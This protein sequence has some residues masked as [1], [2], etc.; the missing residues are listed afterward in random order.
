MFELGLGIRSTWL[1]QHNV[2]Q[3]VC[4]YVSCSLYPHTVWCAP[5]LTH[6]STPNT[7]W[8]D[9]DHFEN[10]RDRYKTKLLY[11]YMCTIVLLY[12]NWLWQPPAPRSDMAL[13]RAIL[14]GFSVKKQDH[15]NNTEMIL[16]QNR[17]QH[18]CICQGTFDAPFRQQ[19]LL[20]FQQEVGRGATVQ[21]SWPMVYLYTWVGSVMLKG[22]VDG[23]HGRHITFPIVMYNDRVSL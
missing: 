4:V 14:V 6:L 2:C 19:T 1:P 22:L 20:E 17:R 8:I 3:C 11:I 13:D 16:H 10:T 12:V 18:Q 5:N 23:K 9:T 15:Y 21:Q 7:E